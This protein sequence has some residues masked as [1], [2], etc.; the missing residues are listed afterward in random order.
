MIPT[1]TLMLLFGFIYADP[2]VK[3]E[4]IHLSYGRSPDQMMVTW[5]TSSEIPNSQVSVS[6]NPA[7]GTPKTFTGYSTKF[8]DGG[9]AHHTQYIHRTLITGLTPGTKYYY[10]CSGSEGIWSDM[11]WF[12]TMKEGSA[13]SPRLV[14]FGDMGKVNAQSLPRLQQEL[15]LYDAVL[16][17][18]DFAYDFD[19]DNATVGDDFMRQIQSVAG[20]L[21][22][23]TCPG[24]HE[25]AYNFSNYKNRFTMPR[26]EDSSRMFYSF[27]IGPAHIVS[28]S[29]EFYY[30]VK[31]GVMQIIR[32]FEW[33]EEDLKTAN[34]PENRAKQPW[35]ITMG[36]RPMYCSNADHDDCTKD[37]DLV[38]VGVPGLHLLGLENMFEKYG[39]DIEMWAHEHSYERLWPVFNRKVYNGSYSEPY[40]NPG[41]PVHIVTGSAGCKERIDKFIKYPPSWSAVRISDYGYTRM[42][43]YNSS[44]VYMEQVSDDKDGA[45]IDRVMVIKDRHGPYGLRNHSK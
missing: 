31:Y 32:Q 4:Q 26:D 9:S 33:L 21:P 13:W 34:L 27:N 18:G 24:N 35:I 20:Y 43:I 39:V 40:T 37:E 16:H 28:F 44:H 42:N 1:V 14:M 7:F 3:P 15:D 38:R 2:D 8:V 10:K 19:T 6:D 22:Y 29:T 30:Y 45:I 25:S 12:S 17:I 5:S 11:M 36:H 41:A 23:M